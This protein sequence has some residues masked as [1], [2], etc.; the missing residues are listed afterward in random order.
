[1]RTELEKKYEELVES[2]DRYYLSSKKPSLEEL[3]N[4]EDLKAEIAVLK[5]QGAEKMINNDILLGQFK[6]HPDRVKELTGTNAELYVMTKDQLQE[7]AE[8]W[9]KEKSKKDWDRFVEWFEVCYQEPFG[10][11][12]L[13]EVKEFIKGK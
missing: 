12:A 2:L 11:D 8:S 13:R 1:M 4:T 6:M 3:I 5:E 10:T 7:Y 9:F